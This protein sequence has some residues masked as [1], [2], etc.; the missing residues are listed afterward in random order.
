MPS[1]F[2]TTVSAANASGVNTRKERDKALNTATGVVRINEKRRMKEP[3]RKMIAICALLIDTDAEG[4][5][6]ESAL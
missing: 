4:K 6:F 1:T 2:A 3:F 5:S